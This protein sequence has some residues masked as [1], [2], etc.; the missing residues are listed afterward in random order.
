MPADVASP[1]LSSVTFVIMLLSQCSL[2]P[3]YVA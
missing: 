2:M 3:R 1:F